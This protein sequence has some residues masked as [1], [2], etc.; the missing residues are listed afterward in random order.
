M[1]IFFEKS[2]LGRSAFPN[3]KE[4]FSKQHKN[5]FDKKLQHKNTAAEDPR[6]SYFIVVLLIFGVRLYFS[7]KIFAEIRAKTPSKMMNNA[8]TAKEIPNAV[9]SSV[10][11]SSPP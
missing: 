2:F 11:P 5:I 4:F 10:N 7:L 3:E 8:Q 6:P 9:H 1:P